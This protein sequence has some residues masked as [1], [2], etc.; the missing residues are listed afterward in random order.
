MRT[1]DLSDTAGTRHSVRRI[2]T[3]AKEKGENSLV[4]VEDDG[5]RLS[6]NI[7]DGTPDKDSPWAKFKMMVSWYRKIPFLTMQGS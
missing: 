6:F 4:S 1:L 3:N 5:I 7:F 2:R